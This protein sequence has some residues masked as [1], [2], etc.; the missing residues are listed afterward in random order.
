MTD[1]AFSDA[2]YERF[3]HLL[4]GRTGLE[5]PQSRRGDLARAVAQ[6][7]RDTGVRDADAFFL[8]LS[9]PNG[10]GVLD[11][12][13]P[14]LSINETH[15]F[16][17]RPQME[18]LEQ[19]ILPDLIERRRASRQL[20]I[21]SAACSSGEE[22]YSVAMMVHGLL[23]DLERW[24]VRIVATDIDRDILVKARRGVY[25]AWSFREV[26]AHVKSTYFEPRGA[27]FEVAPHIRSMVEFRQHNLVEDAPAVAR[28]DGLDL[29]ICRNVLI[30]FN[31]ETI[32]TV[33]ARLY[34]TL[35]PEGWLVVGHAEPSLELFHQFQVRNFPGTVVYQRPSA[36]R[37]VLTSP[38]E[39]GGLRSSPQ[40]A[41]PPVRAVPALANRSGTPAHRAARPA[42]TPRIVAPA[43]LA[44]APRPAPVSPPVRAGLPHAPERTHAEAYAEATR[45]LVAGRS[46]EVVRLLEPVAAADARE[47]RGPYLIAKAH[48]SANR[49]GEAERLVDEALA[50]SSLLAAAHYLRG[51]ILHERGDLDGAMEAHRRA[52]FADPDFVLGHFAL[53]DL[54]QRSG[55]AGRARKVLDNVARIL[56][57]RDGDDSIPD[58]DGLT[59]GRLR[60]LVTTQRDFAA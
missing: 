56:D 3:R 38:R 17:N 15:F 21:W 2:D 54:F 19:R 34:D 27:H 58:G 42:A 12:W 39:R 29:V 16:R 32:R 43:R 57:G 18:A 25:G 44:P 4:R 11:A 7:V 47:P 23:P 26:P 51:L 46:D 50:R 49:L 6:G 40:A 5:F 36:D 9:G 33:L 10:A 53:A 35:V 8:S 14:A 13:T 30:Y 20:R 24:D 37:A 55:Q 48:A 31:Q 60:D 52:T 41:A 45:L 59:V 28:S 1:P 22:P